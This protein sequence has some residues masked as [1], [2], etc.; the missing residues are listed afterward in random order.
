MEIE[1]TTRCSGRPIITRSY[2]NR[3]LCVTCG[4][5]G[6]VAADGSNDHSAA[7]STGVEEHAP[8]RA[9]RLPAGIMLTGDGGGRWTCLRCGAKGPL[10]QLG[11]AVDH[12]CPPR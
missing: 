12:T 2:P 10:A 11:D 4:A 5:S 1:T 8:E 3:W 9:P 6:K 7:P